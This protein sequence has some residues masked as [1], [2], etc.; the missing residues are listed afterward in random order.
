MEFTEYRSKVLQS[1]WLRARERCSLNERSILGLPGFS[2]GAMD[3]FCA[4]H[5]K[6]EYPIG[7]CVSVMLY[8][9]EGLVEDAV[10]AC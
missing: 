1:L 3:N 2:T 7:V 6:C 5:W 4:N 8:Y 10:L 9:I